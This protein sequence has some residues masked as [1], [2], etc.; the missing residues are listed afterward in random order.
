LVILTGLFRRRGVI[1]L[2]RCCRSV[3]A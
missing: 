3:F 2:T 1:T